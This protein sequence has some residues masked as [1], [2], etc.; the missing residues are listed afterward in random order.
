MVKKELKT[1]SF[2]PYNKMNDKEQWIRI[3][4]GCPHNCP[5]CYEPQ[6]IKVFPIPA[7]GRPLVKIMD[8]NLLCK[9]EALSIIRELGKT[10]VTF[11]LICGIDYRF[12]TQEIADA[13]HSAKFQNIRLAWDWFVADQMKIKDALDMLIKAGYASKMIMVFMICNWRI[14]YEENCWK[15]DLLKI[16]RVKAADCWFD[17]QFGRNKFPIWWSMAEI[18]QFRAKVRKHNQMVRF[19]I[20]P[21]TDRYDKKL[22]LVPAIKLTGQIAVT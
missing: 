6:E 20:D 18:K 5:Y 8:M 1:Y 21:E 11:E 16:W 22:L 13:L 19:G 2:G 12:L 9:P 3:T 14:S 15:L 17:N 4:E 7:I 10:K